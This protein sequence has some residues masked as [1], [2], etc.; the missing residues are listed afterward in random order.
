M[1]TTSIL[2][3]YVAKF[4]I[5]EAIAAPSLSWVKRI[6]VLVKGEEGQD[7]IFECVTRGQLSQYTKN[8]DT[9]SNI[10]DAG[11]TIC[12]I[13]RVSDFAKFKDLYVDGQFFTLI[14]SEDWTDQEVA[15]A[16]ETGFGNFTG[17]KAAMFKLDEQNKNLYMESIK[18][19]QDVCCFAHKQKEEKANFSNM[20]YAF[21]SLLSRDILDNRQ[22]IEMPVSD[23]IIALGLAEK[24]FD[25]RISFVT[26]DTDYGPRLSLF[27]ISGEPVIAPYVEKMLQLDIQAAAISATNLYKPNMTASAISK[28]KDYIEQKVISKYVNPETIPAITFYLKMNEEGWIAKG[29]ITMSSIKA[30][31]RYIITITKE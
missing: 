25:E 23:N 9:I 8:V 24:L 26:T 11:S 12:Y 10:F 2:R 14:F 6:A 20:Y 17:V 3:N 19:K 18:G 30:L 5:N 21:G 7:G 16:F 1:E 15:A 22:Y 27:C 28:I 13:V 4:E 29:A 31:W